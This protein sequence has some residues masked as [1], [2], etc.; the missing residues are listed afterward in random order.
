MP[1]D[2]VGHRRLLG[3]GRDELLGFLDT[4]GARRRRFRV[5]GLGQ[6]AREALRLLGDL[7]ADIGQARTLGGHALVGGDLR[8][9]VR[10]RQQSVGLLEAAGLD[11]RAHERGERLHLLASQVGG[12]RHRRDDRTR[13][14]HRDD[15]RHERHAAHAPRPLHRVDASLDHGTDVVRHPLDGLLRRAQRTAQ[16]LERGGLVVGDAVEVGHAFAVLAARRGIAR[17]VGEPARHRLH[18]L[19]ELGGHLAAVRG[20]AMLERADPVELGARA[21]L[22]LGGALGFQALQ[23]LRG[24]LDRALDECRIEP[25]TQPGRHLRGAGPVPL[26]VLEPLHA[27]LGVLEAPLAEVLLE[28]VTELVGGHRLEC[29]AV[30]LPRR[31]VRVAGDQLAQRLQPVPRRRIGQHQAAHQRKAAAQRRGEGDRLL[32][33]ADGLGRHLLGHRQAVLRAERPPLA[34]LVGLEGRGH[35]GDVRLGLGLRAGLEPQALPRV[36]HGTLHAPAQRSR[37]LGD[38]HGELAHLRIVAQAPGH[39]GTHRLEEFLLR[40]HRLVTSTGSSPVRRRG[41]WGRA[42]R[43]RRASRTDRGAPWPRST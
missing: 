42:A 43:A 40:C 11:V 41:P 23:A 6:Q 12:H 24:L 28:L 22:V 1:A 35:L 21:Q 3:L 5:T 34:H 17:P 9:Q 10:L 38:A 30:F 27:L 20:E 13:G 29:A 36:L 15:C 26:P 37:L 32:D 25:P 4:V 31:V 8:A 33:L 39:H 19:G 14:H 2:P 18:A 16:L 7:R